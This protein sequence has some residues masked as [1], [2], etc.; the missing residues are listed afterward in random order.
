M[1]YKF[2]LLDADNTIYDFDKASKA[3]FFEAMSDNKIVIPEESFHRYYEINNLMW[4]LFERGEMP[5]QMIETERYS[6][7]FSEYGVSGD[8][9]AV[10]NSYVNRLATHAELIDGAEEVLA[11]LKNAGLRLFIITNGI[12]SVQTG[13]YSRSPLSK[14]I[15][16]IFISEVI[17]YQKPMKEFFDAVYGKIPGFEKNSAIVV[18][19]SLTSDILGANNAGLPAVW[20]NPKGKTNSGLAIA[21]FEIKRLSELNDLLI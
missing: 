11:L 12:E 10:N 16:Q 15:E 7:F 19:D 9:V 4:E 1:K 5:K 21:D 2:V 8:P 17:G 18:G 6:R 13:R 14:Y 3:A 20:Y